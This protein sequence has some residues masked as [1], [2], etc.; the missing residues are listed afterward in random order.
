MDKDNKRVVTGNL[1]W[2]FSER[3]LAQLVAFI[4]SVVIARILE[5]DAYGT[6]A[7]ITVFTHIM[8]VFVDS[9]LGNALIQ[10]KDADDV[11]FSTVFYTNVT[12]CT[13]LYLL[14][15]IVSPA[16]ARFYNDI[17]LVPYIRVLGLTILISGV[18]NIQNAYVS[19]HMQFKRFFFAT[20][21]GTI[22]AGVVGVTMAV[23]GLG[24]WALVGQHIVNTFI[25]T[26]ILWLTVKWRPIKVFSWQRLK[27]LF[28]FGWKMLASSLLD[29]V[30]KDL[31]QLIIGKGYTSR[32]LAYYNQGQKMPFLVINNINKSIDS[33]IFPAMSKAQED[34]VHMKNMTRRSIMVSVYIMAPIMMGLSA[35]GEPLVKLILT[36]KWL[37]IVPFMRIFCITY[38]FWPI[39]TANLNA[40]KALGRSGTFL[41]LEIMK[42]TIGLIVMLITMRISVMAMAYSLLFTSVTSQIIN[43][44]P[45]RKLLDY[46]YLEQL[47]D[48]FPGIALSVV[49]GFLVMQIGR[50]DAPVLLI[51]FMQVIAGA[52]IYIYGSILFK[53]E[54]FGYVLEI[55]KSYLKN[56]KS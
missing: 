40:I 14:L 47:K 37:P 9:G 35:I 27:G 5:P 20:L 36:D 50:I 49:M 7:L 44:W 8:Q 10:K 4:V 19:K 38:I 23:K 28:N 46:S 1:F 45:N 54:S 32:D 26:V 13:V 24:V 51:L 42:K 11:D 2:R 31:R 33:V 30:Y 18:K 39:H 41:K 6:V 25:D 17:S 16:I 21:G 29:T 48:I 34:K 56:F 3:I 15:F 52:V 55:V 22:I 43:S 12:F 53:I